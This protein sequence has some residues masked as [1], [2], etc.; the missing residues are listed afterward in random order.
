MNKH[1]NSVFLKELIDSEFIFLTTTAGRKSANMF[2]QCFKFA[3][4]S[5]YNILDVFQLNKSL[6]QFVRILY[7]LQINKKFK[8]YI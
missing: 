8:I 2:S 3:S 1:L 7:F 4:D 6:K 5:N